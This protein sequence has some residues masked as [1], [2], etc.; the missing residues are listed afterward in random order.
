MFMFIIHAYSVSLLE[1]FIRLVFEQFMKPNK[2]VFVT[3]DRTKIINRDNITAN[4][5]VLYYISQPQN[6]IDTAYELAH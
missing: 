2:T 6:S 3:A 1:L 4:T 5:Q